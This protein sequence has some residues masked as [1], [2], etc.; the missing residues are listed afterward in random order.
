[1]KL[2][3]ENLSLAILNFAYLSSVVYIPLTFL[4]I[5]ITNKL[6]PLI[7]LLS[8]FFILRADIKRSDFIRFGALFFLAVSCLLSV[9]SYMSLAYSFVVL[10]LLSF[11]IPYY[12]LLK[13]YGHDFL[14]RH[15]AF[16][17]FVSGVAATLSIVE[18]LIPSSIDFLF[19]LRGSIY[20]EKGQV[21]SLFSNPNVFGLMMAFSC[22]LAIAFGKS[23]ISVIGFL[24]LFML[25]VVFSGSRM[26]MLVVLAVLL[27]SF[28]RLPR[29]S[30]KVFL[31]MS[32]S[33]SA[34]LSLNNDLIAEVVDLNT[35]GE[36]WSGV[37][38]A[39]KENPLFGI[40]LGQF[41]ADVASY[42][43]GFADQAANNFFLGI[44]AELGL[45]GA[46]LMFWLLISPIWVGGEYINERLWT[47]SA[48]MLML[49]IASQFSEYMVLYVAP[50]VLM[51]TLFVAVAKWSSHR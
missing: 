6:L 30:H 8:I 50:Y 31:M 9:R 29:P 37:M 10:S 39:F 2:K 3:K 19:F 49:L 20:S 40:G 28:V 32:V 14:R 35:R 15:I 22:Y 45:V 7:S 13:M 25:G 23:K 1:M 27:L 24:A 33:V 21:S 16:I 4:D 48:T 41:Q 43:P 34:F 46:G 47:H 36:I 42:A 51:L 17:L 38:I 18:Y 5:A 12:V 11:G 44:L 26:A